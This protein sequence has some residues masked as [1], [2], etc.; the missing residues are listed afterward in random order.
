MSPAR[1]FLA[2]KVENHD[3]VLLHVVSSPRPQVLRATIQRIYSAKRGIDQRYIGKEI[4]FV[5]SPGNWGDVALEVGERALVFIS[6]V[7][8]RF[9]EDTWRGHMI[10][11]E[12]QGDLFAIY[13]HRELW[14]CEEVPEAIRACSQQ[15]PK[16][17][18]A[19]AILFGILEAYL[20]ELI[21]NSQQC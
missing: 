5:R 11:E 13:Q 20:I 19:T 6:M 14:L 21:E 12:I 10:I 7:S 8:D 18:Y 17:P 1:G 16:R 3:L 2:E 15:D 9:Y 4:E